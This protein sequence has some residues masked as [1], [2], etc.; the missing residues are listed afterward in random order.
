MLIHTYAC[1]CGSYVYAIDHPLVNLMFAK[2]TLSF[3]WPTPAPFRHASRACAANGV[4]Q[5]LQNSQLR[6]VPLFPGLGGFLHLDVVVLNP[7]AAAGERVAVRGDGQ[8][9]EVRE[10]HL[11]GL[12]YRK[13]FL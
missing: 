11:E 3:E 12:A 7:H 2:E 5:L 4:A 8:R 1:N 9:L 13:H 10:S 6:E